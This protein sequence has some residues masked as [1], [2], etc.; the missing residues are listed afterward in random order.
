MKK[1]LITFL[2][3]TW[4]IYLTQVFSYSWEKVWDIKCNEINSV[5]RYSNLSPSIIT[6][7]DLI[8]DK[9][10][11]KYIT[12]DNTY[13]EKI[14]NLYIK[15]LNQYLNKTKYS[16]LQKEV[17]LRIWDYFV[18]KKEWLISK[19]NLGVFNVKISDIT[20]HGVK[21]TWKW[22]SKAETWVYVK[23]NDETGQRNKAFNNFFEYNNLAPNYAF[24]LFVQ[25]VG[26]DVIKKIYFR[27]LD[28]NL[29][30]E[31]TNISKN[32]YLE[33][34][35]LPECDKN[36]TEVFFIENNDDWKHIN[37][38]DKRIFC[39][40]P[41]DYRS[42]KNIVLI[43]SWTKEKRRYI[44]LNNWNDIH[45]GKLDKNQLANY[46]LQFNAAS[47]WIID[48]ATSFDTN[49]R[50]SFIIG[51]GSMYN[52][53]NRM[54]TANLH[55]TMWIRNNAHNNTIQNSRFDW[56]SIQWSKDD[57]STVNI[58]ENVIS[59]VEIKNTKIINNEFLDH[60][61]MRLARAPLTN[62]RTN[63]NAPR[64]HANFEGTI[65]DSNTVEYTKRIR[66]DCNGNFD[67][68]WACM[69]SEGGPDYKSGSDNVNNPV[70]F[71]NNHFWGI[72]PG[73]SNWGTIG[74]GAGTALVVYMGAKHVKIRNNIIFDGTNGFII[75]DKYDAKYWTEYIEVT[76]NLLYN[77][78]VRSKANNATSILISQS[79]NGIVENNIFVNSRGAWA[80]I[81]SNQN[82]FFGNNTVINSEDKY[83]L[84]SN[85]PNG[86]NTNKIYKTSKEAWYTKD[87]SFVTD[88]FTNNPRT[89]TLK[90]ALKSY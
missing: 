81:R 38:K 25:W 23:K 37:D 68:N 67:I 90:N 76:G 15:I 3:L 59:F 87:Y 63:H 20:D 36:D 64:Q 47:Y 35:D 62:D 6:K 74:A 10:N 55:H 52:I 66:T 39:V 4:V 45:P 42:L 46:A 50:H 70:I 21:V 53:F 34:I 8:W 17:L 71:S 69:I 9:I 13:K 61:P 79:L 75:A 73:Q 84:H 40:S 1:I 56:V 65:F 29:D 85:A 43:T 30:V 11:N 83:I 51:R 27:T 49:I 33:D 80:D 19:E 44:V 86:M 32:K 77:L 58:L 12:K 57:L 16:E 5:K 54:F 72:R 41:G 18:C 78:G 89:I 14:Y 88:K 7:I 48:R 22:N 2:L 31:N 28:D 60:K 82:L 26:S 24:T